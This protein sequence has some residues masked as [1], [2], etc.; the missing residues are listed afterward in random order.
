MVRIREPPII[1]AQKELDQWWSRHLG[2]HTRQA[3]GVYI[4]IDA[5][6]KEI[7]ERDYLQKIEQLV[8]KYNL[9]ANKLIRSTF[10]NYKIEL[11]NMEIPEHREP[12]EPSIG[13]TIEAV[14]L[15]RVELDI[16]EVLQEPSEESKEC[17]PA[18]KSTSDRIDEVREQIENLERELSKWNA[19]M[20]KLCHL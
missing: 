15:D 3:E 6:H 7:Y 9:P 1:N 12:D 8:A 5:E 2:V 20:A 14:E 10:D 18:F 16:S 4:F 13:I 11:P 17:D 19:E